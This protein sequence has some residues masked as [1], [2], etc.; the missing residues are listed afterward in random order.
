MSEPCRTLIGARGASLTGSTCPSQHTPFDAHTV[1]AVL[2]LGCFSSHFCRAGQAGRR[3]AGN[4]THAST[5][6]AFSSFLFTPVLLCHAAALHLTPQ[7]AFCVFFVWTQLGFLRT[8]PR[9]VQLRVSAALLPSSSIAAV[10][11]RSSGLSSGTVQ[12]PKAEHHLRAGRH[13]RRAQRP[14]QDAPPNCTQR[15]GT[16]APRG[17][18]REMQGGRAWF[19]QLA[20]PRGA[21]TENNSC[22]PFLL[23]SSRSGVPLFPAATPLRA[24]ACRPDRAPR[25]APAPPSVR[26]AGLRPEPGAG[27]P[28]RAV[29]AP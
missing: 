29:P 3:S 23:R 13:R 27:L 15:H 11:T 26:W 6:H 21:S 2:L 5:F 18:Q 25:A 10:P 7:I 17:T 22:L 8:P 4:F 12:S 24:A 9:P 16:A 28:T 20:E 19:S 14:L 1:P